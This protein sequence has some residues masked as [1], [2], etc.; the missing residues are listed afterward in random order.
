MRKARKALIAA[1]CACALA[2]GAAGSL[3]YFTDSEAAVNT[4]TVGKVGISLDEAKVNQDGKPMSG[5]TVV[6]SVDKADRVTSNSYHLIPG[7]TYVKDPTVTVLEGSDASY[8]RMIVE[9]TDIENL[10]KAFDSTYM[11]N[12]VFLLERIVG[13]WDSQEWKFV[14][15]ENGVYE[16]RY[17]EAVAA[18]DDGDD[19]TA[20]NVVLPELF[21]SITIP[22]DEIDNDELALL[23]DVTVNVTAQAI[24]AA[25]FADADAAWASWK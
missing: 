7:T 25:G 17:C 3:A 2:L 20:T 18:P 23:K 24:Q 13:G 6:D 22:G 21:A 16:F 19:S 8:V 9:V 5:D 4:F 14:G 10:K 1:V 12:G 11:S 15:Y